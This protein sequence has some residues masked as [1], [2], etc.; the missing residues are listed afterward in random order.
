MSEPLSYDQGVAILGYVNT[1][2][3]WRRPA[4]QHTAERWEPGLTIVCGAA[5]DDN[6]YIPASSVSLNTRAAIQALRDACDE[7]LKECEK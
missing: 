6:V 2:V 4:N 3:S 7:A 5:V 1:M